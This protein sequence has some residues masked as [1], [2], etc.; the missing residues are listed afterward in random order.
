M[1]SNIN[2]SFIKKYEI[3]IGEFYFH[4]NYVIGEVYAGADLNFE[5]GKKLYE[6]IKIHYKDTIPYA[7]I[8]NRINSYSF[9]PTRLYAMND[10]F[11]NLKGYGIVT[12]DAVNY[13]VAELE[14]TFTKIPTQVFK[15]LENATHWAE[16]ITSKS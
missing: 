5:S 2:K 1:V 13:K 9:K 14:E 10:N 16:K 6:L 3:E 8:S 4:K 12:Y 11:P 15:N 7:Y